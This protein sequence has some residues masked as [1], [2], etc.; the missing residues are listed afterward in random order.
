MA[1]LRGLIELLG[2]AD[3]DHG[4]RCLRDSQHIGK[5]HLCRLIHEQHVHR[6]KSFGRSP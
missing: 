4:F 5:R 2:I 3:Q 6:L 1:A